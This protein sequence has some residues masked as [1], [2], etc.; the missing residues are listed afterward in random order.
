MTTDLASPSVPPSPAAAPG[1][2]TLQ[3]IFGAL[4]A[5]GETFEDIARRPNILGPLLVII[6]FGYISTAL[7]LPRMDWDAVISM[8]AEQMKAKNP[9]MSQ[10]DIN[11]MGRYSKSFGTAIAWCAPLLGVAWYAIVAGTLLLAFRVMGGESD[12][13]Q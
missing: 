12:F 10:E 2:N 11:R 4:F 3:R 7:I 1:K 6:V 8:Q 13:K 5:P 9:N